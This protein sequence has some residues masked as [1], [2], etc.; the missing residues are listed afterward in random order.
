MSLGT[1]YLDNCL[2][3]RLSGTFCSFKSVPAHVNANTTANITASNSMYTA[4]STVAFA[5]DGTHHLVTSLQCTAYCILHQYPIWLFQPLVTQFVLSVSSQ[6]GSLRRKLLNLF[7]LC[8]ACA[9]S[10]GARR[11]H[12]RR[13]LQTAWWKTLLLARR[14]ILPSAAGIC[15][16]G[17]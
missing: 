17:V 4:R 6:T 14:R 5:Y 11:F 1:Y 16:T 15:S 8:P 9:L 7:Q 2:S 3:S 10:P 12:V 13:L